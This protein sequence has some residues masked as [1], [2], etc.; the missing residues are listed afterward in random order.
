MGVYKARTLASPVHVYLRVRNQ[1]QM[2]MRHE[3]YMEMARIARRSADCRKRHVGAVLVPPSQSTLYVGWNAAPP[4]GPSCIDGGCHR[5][6]NPEK[7][8]AGKGYDVCICVH[9]E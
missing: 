6:A 7:Y 5:C 8:P 2:Y 4:T 9:A 1:R 3:D